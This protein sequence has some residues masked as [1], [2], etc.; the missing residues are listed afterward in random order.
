M[1][2]SSAPQW[3][4][5]AETTCLNR[6]LPYRL[7]F[8]GGQPLLR[9]ASGGPV[10]LECLTHPTPTLRPALRHGVVWRLISHLTLNH[11]SL[12]DYEEGADALREILR[13]YDFSDS[14][15]VRGVID[16]ILSVRTRRVVGR[17]GGDVRGGFCRG[18]EVNIRFDE[19]R[20]VGTGVYLFAAVLERFLSLYCSINS[21][22]RTVAT[23]NKREG[24]LARWPPR[25]GETTL[26]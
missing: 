26:L 13:L 19:D 22:S 6:D 8:G 23:T 15:Q 16:G 21:F 5:H 14:A 7:P 1:N 20:Y 11:L 4:V 10:R 9:L 3:T 17:L 18:I 2:P 12:I 24:E 25:S